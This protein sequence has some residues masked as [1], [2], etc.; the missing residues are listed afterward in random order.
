MQFKCLPDIFS[1][2]LSVSISISEFFAD[3]LTNPGKLRPIFGKLIHLWQSIWMSFPKS[4]RPSKKSDFSRTNF[5]M[6]VFRWCIFATSY[7][8]NCRKTSIRSSRKLLCRIYFATI[9]NAF[10]STFISIRNGSKSLALTLT[11]F[12]IGQNSF[13]KSSTRMFYF[14]TEMR[15]GGDVIIMFMIW[16]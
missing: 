2:S 8:Y 15:R 13:I 4:G 7:W 5:L 6:K 11:R 10:M 12:F 1:V 16:E 9:W 3:K 14:G